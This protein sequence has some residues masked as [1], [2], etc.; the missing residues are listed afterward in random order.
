[1]LRL[2][3]KVA[4]AGPPGPTQVAVTESGPVAVSNA[5]LQTRHASVDGTVAPRSTMRLVVNTSFQSTDSSTV[6]YN[7]CH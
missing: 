5:T 1:M 2:W 4:Q 7:I 3:R 6:F